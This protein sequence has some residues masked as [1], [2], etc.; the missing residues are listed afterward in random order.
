MWKASWVSV[1]GTAAAY[2]LFG[3]TRFGPQLLPSPPVPP[4]PA[5]ETAPSFDNHFTYF[6]LQ[7][8]SA[9]IQT[10]MA[11]EW[12]MN[13]SILS[14]SHKGNHLCHGVNF[15]SVQT[16]LTNITDI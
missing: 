15:G 3:S 12:Q 5:H 8:T 2:G 4:L 14:C 7:L 11:K 16:W 10:K 6:F 1:V 13:I 9:Q